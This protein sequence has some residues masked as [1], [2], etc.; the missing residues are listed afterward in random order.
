MAGVSGGGRWCFLR[1][2]VGHYGAIAPASPPDDQHPDGRV[3]SVGLG[4]CANAS[5]A[6]PLPRGLSL[7]IR[8]GSSLSS[9]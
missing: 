4:W 7:L 6:P 2:F 8:L 5:R 9:P 1:V 3:E